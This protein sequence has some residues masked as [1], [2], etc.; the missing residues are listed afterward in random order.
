MKNKKQNSIKIKS[1][2][3]RKRDK[4]YTPNTL[5]W[6]FIF[7]AENRQ[8]H[9]IAGAF[10]RKY[11]NIQKHNTGSTFLMFN[12]EYDYHYLLYT[13]SFSLYHNR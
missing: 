7:L 12:N 5:T 13:S 9:L 3:C 8:F 11:Q 2:N 1:E 4:I 10:I 6:S